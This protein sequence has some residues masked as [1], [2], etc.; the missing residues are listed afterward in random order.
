MEWLIWFYLFFI[1][2]SLYFTFLFLI[3]F[4]KNKTT[5]FVAQEKRDLPK[6][7]VLIP[8]Y[9]EED[10]IEGT[11]QAVLDVEYPKN[12]MEVIV[13][14]DGSTDKTL[15]LASKSE[16]VKVLNKKNG[17][18]ADS[19]NEGLKIAKNELIVVVDADSYPSKDSFLKMVHYFSDEKVG[20][21]TSCIM[22]KEPK[23]LIEKLQATEYMFIAFAR[24]LLDYI[25]SIYVTPGP[26]SIYRKKA[27]LEVGGFDTKN[28]TEDIE[29]AWNLLKNKYDIRM[30]L[31]ARVYTKC[32]SNLRSWWKQRVRWNVGGLQTI[33][34]YKNFILKKRFN[35]FGLF[36]TPFFIF[37]WILSLLGLFIFGYVL[38]ERILFSILLTSSTYASG[39]GLD[40]SL[41]TFKFNPTVFFFFVMALFLMT[42]FYV[43]CCFSVM[44]RR[45]VNLR[46]GFVLLVYLLL[47]L[48]IS[49]LI[50]IH[51][52]IRFSM[53]NF[54]W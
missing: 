24:R 50:H 7:S 41:N 34:K 37:S 43:V 40:L 23:K 46:T 1:F 38:F 28:L 3:I 35:M 10:T 53:G 45:L 18:K 11:I 26:L 39:S 47:Y 25:G 29:I 4:W 13:I 49:P 27:L 16:N 52:I 17:G 22:V 8:A 51:A 44:G 30:A 54:Q 31:D 9:N 5:L 42:L 15:E 48:S 32:K 12:L 20:A 19:L 21:V 14:N 33:F 36:V 2:V 6:L